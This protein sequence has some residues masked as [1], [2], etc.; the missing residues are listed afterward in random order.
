MSLLQ[1]GLPASFFTRWS[2][3]A[4]G[5][6]IGALG[7]VGLNA[8][9]A[10]KRY[11]TE[12]KIAPACYGKN[13]VAGTLSI[14]GRGLLDRHGLPFEDRE[15]SV[16]ANDILAALSACT[17]QSCPR[18]ERKKYRSAMYRYFYARLQHTSQ[19]YRTY[20]DDGLARARQIY[21]EPID[22]K[23]E[24]G[25]RERYAAGVFRVNDFRQSQAAIAILVLSGSGALRPCRKGESGEPD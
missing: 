24:Q 13:H 25:L 9:A 5:L 10:V 8:Y 21:R 18:D 23:V 17:P 7:L 16:K 22:L 4:A 15:A 2:A 19:L 20:G 12:P 3:V 6:L 11:V 14:P 1:Q